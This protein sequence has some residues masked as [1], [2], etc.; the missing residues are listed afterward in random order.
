MEIAVRYDMLNLFLFANCKHLTVVF[1]MTVSGSLRIH[2][3]ESD[4]YSK[5]TR[6]LGLFLSIGNTFSCA[7]W[8]P[9]HL[10]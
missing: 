9:L 1:V 6:I 7:C 5:F 2:H 3:V 8:W 10:V 4:S